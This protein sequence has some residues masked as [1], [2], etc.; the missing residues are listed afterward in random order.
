MC[1]SQAAYA[2]LVFGAGPINL[3]FADAGL[4][5]FSLCSLAV[6]NHDVVFGRLPTCVSRTTL[7]GLATDA[8]IS[9]ILQPQDEVAGRAAVQLTSK[10]FNR[11]EQ[12][13]EASWD[14]AGPHSGGIP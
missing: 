4:T 6:A 7:V 12:R 9:L 1:S 14:A 2:R 13:N 8:Y 5:S 3:T 11:L 10:A